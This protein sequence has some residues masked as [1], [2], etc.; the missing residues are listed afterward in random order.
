MRAKQNVAQNSV[1]WKNSSCSSPQVMNR[2][3]KLAVQAWS[4]LPF[5]LPFRDQQAKQQIAKSKCRSVLKIHGI[6]DC[7]ADVDTD[8]YQ[9]AYSQ[10]PP[11]GD[12]P[13]THQ[14]LSQ[15][16]GLYSFWVEVLLYQVH[17]A[18]FQT[19]HCMI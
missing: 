9:A 5:G 17:I 18:D 4:A 13:A 3:E 1:K 12:V 11:L 15:E 10:V 7:G 19:K 14:V 16:G 6:Q 2:C 8:I